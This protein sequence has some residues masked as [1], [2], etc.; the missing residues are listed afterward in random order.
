MQ[1]SHNWGCAFYR[2]SSSIWDHKLKW[3]CSLFY[4]YLTF[5]CARNDSRMSSSNMQSVWVMDNKKVTSVTNQA[6][7]ILAK[8][9]HKACAQATCFY[10]TF[11]SV[12]KFNTNSQDQE[13]PLKLFWLADFTLLSESIEG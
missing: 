12:S 6:G 10:L 7:N 5:L 2:D 1:E 13:D 11:Q 8:Q 9:C 3:N 4:S